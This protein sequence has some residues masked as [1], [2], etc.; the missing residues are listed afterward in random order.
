[1]CPRVCLVPAGQ[2]APDPASYLYSLRPTWR[3]LPGTCF[4]SLAFAVA[5]DCGVPEATLAAAAADYFA[6]IESGSEHP[7]YDAI[8]HVARSSRAGQQS[9]RSSSSAG[10]SRRA[11]SIGVGES[12]CSCSGS[13]L[14]SRQVLEGSQAA[15]VALAAT[16]GDAVQEEGAAGS[17][18]SSPSIRQARLAQ[19]PQGGDSS[20]AE[21]AAARQAAGRVSAHKLFDQLLAQLPAAVPAAAAVKDTATQQVTA[22]AAAAAKQGMGRRRRKAVSSRVAGEETHQQ[23][24]QPPQQQQPPQPQLQDM[25]AAAGADGGVGYGVVHEAVPGSVPPPAHEG[26]SVVY[27]VL[28]EQGFWYGGETQVRRGVALLTVPR[29][30]HSVSNTEGKGGHC[31]CP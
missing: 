23:P 22:A 18:Q 27:M 15:A 10:G 13:S 14:E 20:A 21:K 30:R 24:T 11:S 31:A 4:E 25:S 8:T 19:W 6:I 29:S 28:D 3:L 9:P 16:A 17:Q 26:R 12:V 7:G 1:M 5:R 2:S